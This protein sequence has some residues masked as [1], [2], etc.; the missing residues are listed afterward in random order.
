MPKIARVGD[1]GVGK[2]RAGHPGFPVGTPK[3][4]VTTFIT[5][6]ST[7]FLNN[8]PMAVISDTIGETDCGH[9][10]TAISG[11]S[12]VFAENKPVHRLS[13]LGIINEGAGEYEV[14]SNSDN[15]EGGG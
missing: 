3:D 4:F 12:T 1:I 15:V 13:D 14:I 6:A 9:T 7:V 5:G 11:S 8:V 10:T 2:C